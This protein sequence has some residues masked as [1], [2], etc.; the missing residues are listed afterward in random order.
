MAEAQ[1]SVIFLAS[2]GK[3]DHR[4]LWQSVVLLQN[5]PQ[6]IRRRSTSTKRYAG[7]NI[8]FVWVHWAFTN[9]SMVTFKA[10]SSF[11][12][13]IFHIRLWPCHPIVDP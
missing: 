12:F 6:Q 3:Q 8:Y 1:R 7:G 9:L 10:S 11:I 5:T 2:I 13:L 4:I